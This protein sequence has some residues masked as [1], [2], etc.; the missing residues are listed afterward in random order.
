MVND[1]YSRL[2]SASMREETV[3]NREHHRLPGDILPKLTLTL[4]TPDFDCSA[5]FLNFDVEVLRRKTHD[6][7]PWSSYDLLDDVADIDEAQE[8]RTSSRPIHSCYPDN[9]AFKQL[10]DDPDSYG[11]MD[12]F[13]HLDHATSSDSVASNVLEL[14]RSRHAPPGDHPASLVAQNYVGNAHHAGPNTNA[15]SRPILLLGN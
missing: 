7:P 1:W 4:P 11:T 10:Q 8:L 9:N 15:R 12:T 14:D 6:E 3:K 13:S 5:E 2:T